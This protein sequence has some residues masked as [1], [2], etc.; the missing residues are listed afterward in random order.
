MR[1]LVVGL[2]LLAGIAGAATARAEIGTPDAVPAATLLLPYFEVDLADAKGRGVTTRLAIN[3][4]S[5]GVV[6]AFVTLWSEWWVPVLG[7]NVYLTG[8]DVETIDLRRVIADGVLPSTGP[9]SALSSLGQ[10]SAGPHTTFGGT[11]SAAPGVA[12]NY[13]TLSAAFRQVV[14]QSLTGQPRASDG[15]CAA[16]PGRPG[17]ARGFVTVDVVRECAQAFPSDAG[18]FV[19]GGAGI[20]TND[21]VLWGDYAIVDPANNF[22][23]GFTLVHLEAHFASLGVVDGSCDTV[24]R[25][26]TTFYC[27]LRNP[28][29]FAQAG[30]DNREG[31]PSVFATRYVAGGAFDG[32]TDLLVWRDKNGVGPGVPRACDDPPP[33]LTQAQ[34]VVFDEQENP[35]VQIPGP[36]GEPP[37]IDIPF[38]YGASRARVGADITVEAPFGWLYLNLNDGNPAQEYFRQAFVSTVMSARGRFSVGYEAL[39]LNN[40]TL[41]ADNRRGER[42][43]DPTLGEPPNP[44]A[45]TLFDG[46]P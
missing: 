5:D 18:Y 14:Q 43:P 9:A 45:P 27:G 34:L 39:S 29:G 38:P 22:A 23:Q 33:A 19:D 32:G 1:Q 10:F 15:L 36:V 6:L 31:L 24:D 17:V 46:G 16:A 20:A 42:N 2:V 37:S 28:P 4:A 8:Y 3:N 35:V 12:P 44:N 40:H 21:N 41:G 30:E 25:S 7:F 13:G 26:P 11:C